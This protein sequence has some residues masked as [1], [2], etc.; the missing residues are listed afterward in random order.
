MKNY[1]KV[2]DPNT[3]KVEYETDL[4]S[5]E[6]IEEVIAKYPDKPILYGKKDN[7]SDVVELRKA[8]QSVSKAKAASIDEEK[9]FFSY[10]YFAILKQGSEGND[11]E[12]PVVI[13]ILT[14]NW[15][16]YPDNPFEFI[17]TPSILDE[18]MLEP[19]DREFEKIQGSKY[20]AKSYEGRKG[21][22]ELYEDLLDMGF[23]FSL[24]FD[25]FVNQ[26]VTVKTF[27]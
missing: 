21:E 8:Y 5:Y 17:D 20:E 10:Y 14:S 18:T 11:R 15:H 6:T 22:N 12:H 23:N 9:K 24:E 25:R 2:F 4:S 16:H 7:V 1:V 26:R 19:M 27:D 13:F 3:N